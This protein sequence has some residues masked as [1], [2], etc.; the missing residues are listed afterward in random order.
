M[1]LHSAVKF[2]RRILG[3]PTMTL[4]SKREIKPGNS[5]SSDGQIA[6]FIRENAE[7]I[8]HPVGT[9]RMGADPDSVVDPELKVRGIEG[10]RVVDASIMPTMLSANLNAGAMMIGE[11]GADMILD[12]PALEPII[13]SD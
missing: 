10:L 4:H 11:K 7:T 2:G 3:A 9:C 6:D 5:V 8:Y 1:P 12:K 13:I